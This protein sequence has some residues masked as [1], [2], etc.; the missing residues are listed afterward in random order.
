M[1]LL[2][3]RLLEKLNPTRIVGLSRAPSSSDNSLPVMSARP[4]HSQ[5]CQPT[6]L[7]AGS[8]YR[9]RPAGRC[10]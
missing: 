9:Y 4:I 2:V 6:I 3:A 7:Q 1:S 8:T 10:Q 5:S